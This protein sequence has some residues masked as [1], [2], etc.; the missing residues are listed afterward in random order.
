M[1]FEL[2]YISKDEN[3]KLHEFMVENE[4]RILF[5]KIKENKIAII[6]GVNIFS[7]YEFSYPLCIANIPLT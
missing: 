6:G 1:F 5:G 7:E 4:S 3:A 2:G